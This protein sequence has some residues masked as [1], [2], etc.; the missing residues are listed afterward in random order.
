[1][2]REHLPVIIAE[3]LQELGGA[4]DIGEQECDG[5]LWQLGY[6]TDG[7]SISRHS[8]NVTNE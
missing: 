8:T 3:P 7:R 5:S 1:M 2:R 6:G 4:L